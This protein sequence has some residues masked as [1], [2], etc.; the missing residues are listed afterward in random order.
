MQII[1]APAT[2][3]AS[4]PGKG[5]RSK[6]IDALNIWFKVPE[7]SIVIIKRIIDLLH[8]A[9][10]MLDDIQDG[11]SLRRG[12]PSTHTIFGVGQTINSSSYVIVEVMEEALA[13]RNAECVAIL[14]STWFMAPGCSTF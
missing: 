12:K 4:L 8:N 3:I 10:L 11:S 1:E 5:V 13:L 9:S 2:Y 14:L 7:S 6:V